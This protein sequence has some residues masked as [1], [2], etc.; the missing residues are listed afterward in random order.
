MTLQPMW[1]GGSVRLDFVRNTEGEGEDV[2]LRVGFGLIGADD[3]GF[4]QTRDKSVITGELNEVA[5]MKQVQAAVTDMSEVKLM[6]EQHECG[7]SGSHPNQFRVLTCLLL[8]L[9]VTLAK[10]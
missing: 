2:P 6:A 9:M 10:S 7:A 8:N 1:L 5:V 4:D 3:A